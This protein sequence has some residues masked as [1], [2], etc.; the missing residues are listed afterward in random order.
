MP[1]FGSFIIP[2]LIAR[3][4]SHTRD[5][6]TAFTVLPFGV[7]PFRVLISYSPSAITLPL[8]C[9]YSPIALG[10]ATGGARVGRNP[11]LEELLD[12]VS[13]REDLGAKPET[14]EGKPGTP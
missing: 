9:T 12:R 4:A 10:K 1:L 5:H 2:V 14:E 6:R 7:L 13:G 8:T 11:G 3:A